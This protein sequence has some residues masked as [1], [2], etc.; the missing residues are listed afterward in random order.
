MN[1]FQIIQFLSIE[2]YISYSNLLKCFYELGVV[3]MYKV[4]IYFL[5]SLKS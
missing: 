4:D 3:R 2:T 5:F 1:I